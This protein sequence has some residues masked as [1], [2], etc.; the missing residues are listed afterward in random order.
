MAVLL[1]CSRRRWNPLAELLDGTL[2]PAMGLVWQTGE[3]HSVPDPRSNVQ[4]LTSKGKARVV[5]KVNFEDQA[6]A[7]FWRILGRVNET[8]PFAQIHDP[9][10]RIGD[11]HV[12]PAE[13][14]R[15]PDV[16]PSLASH[17]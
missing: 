4:R 10:W 15:H 11:A 17:T 7:E 6:V 13:W 8:A 14:T 12:P 5:W 1:S 9:D 3:K 16:P 2:E